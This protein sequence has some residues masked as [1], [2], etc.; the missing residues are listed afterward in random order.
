VHGYVLRLLPPRPTFAT[1]M[2]DDER[3]LMGEH[4][5]YWAG[6]TEQGRVIAYGPVGDPAGHYGLAV[7]LADSLEEARAL[8]DADPAVLASAGL[9]TEVAPMFALLTP[10]ARY[11]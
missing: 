1:D 2:T 5:V 10:A 7:V 6:L 11:D 4:A 3:A 8:A 9:R